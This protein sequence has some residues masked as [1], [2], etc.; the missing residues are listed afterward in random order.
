[1]SGNVLSHFVS[2]FVRAMVVLLGQRAGMQLNAHLLFAQQL[3]GNHT[4][5]SKFALNY[6]LLSNFG[7]TTLLLSNF[8]LNYCWLSNFGR[9]TLLP[10]SNFLVGAACSNVQEYYMFY[11]WTAS[12]GSFVPVGLSGP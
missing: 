2:G 1:M 8:A 4:P 7:G 5:S 3:W 6:C 12:N 9:S 10:T 11:S